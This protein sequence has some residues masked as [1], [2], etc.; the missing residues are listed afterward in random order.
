MDVNTIILKKG[1]CK[2]TNQQFKNFQKGDTI[3][4]CDSD[5]EEVMRWNFSQENEAKAE[6]DKYFC[7][8]HGGFDYDVTEYALEYCSCDSDGEFIEGSDYYLA[9]EKYIN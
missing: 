1:F 3:F 9:K 6:L 5:P 2:L 8:Y 4:G 7:T